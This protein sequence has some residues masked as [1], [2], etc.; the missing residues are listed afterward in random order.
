MGGCGSKTG[1]PGEDF[2]WNILRGTN[3]SEMSFGEVKWK[4]FGMRKDPESHF[5]VDTGYPVSKNDAIEMTKLFYETD[6][7]KNRYSTYHKKIFESMVEAEFN[8]TL[9]KD[10][11]SSLSSY[12]LIFTVFGFIKK[13]NLPEEESRKERV[14]NFYLVLKNLDENDSVLRYNNFKKSLSR[15]MQLALVKITQAVLEEAINNNVTIQI[16]ES[17]KELLD[18]VYCQKF[19][20]DYLTARCRQFENK[21]KSKI[22]QRDYEMT[23]G[24]IEEIFVDTNC[25]SFFYIQ[26]MRNDFMQ[27]YLII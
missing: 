14:E 6:Q 10:R 26:D 13:A 20:D 9:E 11:K 12:N 8:N 21:Y 17:L 4:V 15:Y 27:T 16:Q 3:L 25:L 5:T 24:D 1:H 19:I 7:R 2:V 23:P 18:K 22:S